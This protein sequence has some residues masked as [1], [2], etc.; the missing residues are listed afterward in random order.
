M[1]DHGNFSSYEGRKERRTGKIRRAFSRMHRALDGWMLARAPASP[2]QGLHHHRP[3][4]FCSDDLKPGDCEMVVDGGGH[5]SPTLYRWFTHMSLLFSSSTAHS[6]AVGTPHTHNNQQTR[7]TIEGRRG[8]NSFVP[9]LRGNGT[10]IAPTGD[11]FDQPPG[12]MSWIRGK[13]A[14]HV[15]DHVVLSPEECVL[16]TSPGTESSYPRLLNR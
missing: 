8:C 5:F 6:R 11:I 10:K 1:S 3:R 13:L 15:G 9:V 16:V 7:S 12:G 2:A 14:D 4:Y